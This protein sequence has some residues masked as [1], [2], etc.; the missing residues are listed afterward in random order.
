M[1]T[2]S[3]P[4]DAGG[5]LVVVAVVVVVRWPAEPM[6]QEVKD[7]KGEGAQPP[8]PCHG[9]GSRRAWGGVPHLMEGGEAQLRRLPQ[10]SIGVDA[11]DVLAEGPAAS[12]VDNVNAML[13]G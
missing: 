12:H 8:A 2:S 10:V 11:D 4:W 5:W 3:G 7:W 9:E 13:G 1:K 6:Q